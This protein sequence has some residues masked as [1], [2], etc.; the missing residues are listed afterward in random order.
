MYNAFIVRSLDKGEEFSKEISN[1]IGLFQDKG[2][3]VEVQ[4]QIHNSG[5][6]ALLLG[7]KK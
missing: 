5:Y 1:T 7:R 6:T 2:L 3:V 4:Y